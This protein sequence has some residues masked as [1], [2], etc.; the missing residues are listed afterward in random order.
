M[1]SCKFIAVIWILG[2][3]KEVERHI[4]QVLA[5]VTVVLQI[6]KCAIY[7]APSVDV[8]LIRVCI[9]APFNVSG[10]F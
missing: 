8:I 6:T 7:P 3:V 5:F 1:I 10:V 2:V 4:F 9:Q